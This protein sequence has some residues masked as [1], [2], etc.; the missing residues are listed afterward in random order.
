[1]PVIIEELA[2]KLEATQMTM[3]C[4]GFPCSQDQ[5]I[6]GTLSILELSGQVRTSH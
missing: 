1:M 6:S 3:A 5:T 4:I 2:R